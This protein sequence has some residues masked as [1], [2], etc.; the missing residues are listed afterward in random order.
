MGHQ[1]RS[2]LQLFILFAT[3]NCASRWTQQ[4]DGLYPL[5][6][7]FWTWHGQGA[8][9]SV[10]H[11]PSYTSKV[12]HVKISE[13][14]L[15]KNC[16]VVKSLYQFFYY[17]SKYLNS[18]KCQENSMS[19]SKCTIQCSTKA[20]FSMTDPLSEEVRN[21]SFPP[22]WFTVFIWCQSLILQIFLLF[23]FSFPLDHYVL[24]HEHSPRTC[25]LFLYWCTSHSLTTNPQFSSQQK[26]SVPCD[27][28]LTHSLLRSLIG[29]IKW[30]PE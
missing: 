27:C 7:F 20:E 15:I 24:G 8:L 1:I 4:L 3:L 23:F 13:N 26:A 21:S 14:F 16:M 25:W 19:P 29:L 10:V 12:Q 17:H 22:H 18:M 11:I 5:W 6:Y 28:H 2:L 9:V 30:W